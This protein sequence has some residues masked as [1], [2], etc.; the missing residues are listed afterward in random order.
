MIKKVALGSSA[1][2]VT[3]LS[4]IYGTI[5]LHSDS[6]SHSHQRLMSATMRASRLGIMG[7]RMASIYAVS[8]NGLKTVFE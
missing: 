5:Y 7:T 4:G 2:T 8:D 6:L 1:V 3:T